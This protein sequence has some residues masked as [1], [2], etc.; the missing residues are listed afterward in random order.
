MP[1]PAG[2]QTIQLPKISNAINLMRRHPN[3]LVI[4]IFHQRYPYLH[5]YLS[6]SFFFIFY[7]DSLS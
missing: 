7:I 4:D 1:E 3:D 2:E 6:I 5:N